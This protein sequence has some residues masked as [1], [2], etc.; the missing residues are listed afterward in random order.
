MITWP[1]KRAHA[2]R[3]ARGR[4]G[5]V[6]T[7][8][9]PTLVALVIAAVIVGCAAPAPSPTWL[10]PQPRPSPSLPA[11][12]PAGSGLLLLTT[13]DGVRSLALV[14][15][16]AEVVAL[17][18]PGPSTM[19]VTPMPDGALVALLADGAAFL[20]PGG[21]SGL[22]AGTGWRALGIRWTGS[23]PDTSMIFGA[24]ASPDGTRLAAI[25]RPPEAESPS[26]LVIIEP[27]A[28]RGV[29]WQLDNESTGVAP[30]WLNASTVAVVQR[31][32]DHRTFLAVLAAASGAASDRISFR[33]LDF[34]TSGDT[35]TAVVLGDENR[36][37]VGPTAE[38]LERRSAPDEGPATYPGDTVRGGV[39]LDQD[40]RHLAAVV[41]DGT[42]ASWIATFE[43]VGDNWQPG[44]RIAAPSG[45]SGGWVAWLP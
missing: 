4:A 27:T 12:G 43:L 29:V 22:L 31:G 39:A 11:D 20:A 8:T 34:H 7:P 6:P 15:P 35:E 33:A 9:P 3:P 41:E 13:V 38:L 24:T 42:G 19:S 32:R 5:G 28:G 23:I 45:S 44:A 18:V 21:P 25:A 30:A 37:L 36:L 16:S 40:G 14:L 17:P 10:T 26:A 1:P 2:S